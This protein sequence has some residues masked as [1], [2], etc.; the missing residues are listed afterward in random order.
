MRIAL[1]Q[2]HASGSREDNLARG[3]AA[4]RK[5]ATEGAE[6]VL[7]A[8]LAFTR[9]FPQYPASASARPPAETIPGPTTDRFAALARECGV[10]VIPNLFE[11]DGD[12]CY[13]A[14]PVI[15]ADGSLLGRT[16]MVHVAESPCFHEQQ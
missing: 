13:D 1:V 2:Q 6:L 15:D 5:A 11:R 14:S 9:F 4:A 10:V 16:R 12:A 7:F 3:L 8:E